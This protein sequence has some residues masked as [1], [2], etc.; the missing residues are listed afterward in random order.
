[1]TVVALH[2]VQLAMPPGG[3][4]RATDFYEGLLD[5]PRVVKPPHLEGRGGCWFETETV[6]IHLGVEEDFRP[7]AKAHPAF[8]VE[9]LESVKQR[10]VD[11]GVEVVDDQP[12]PG[13]GRFYASDP[14]GNRIELLSPAE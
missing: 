13:Y 6:R 2:H 8:H 3:E 12:P 10:F 4:I 7:A 1:M 9:D 14:F 11:A 5:I